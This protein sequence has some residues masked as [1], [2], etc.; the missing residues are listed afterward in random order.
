M[1]LGVL[2]AT[3]DMT[4][5][6]NRQ[7]A[8][9]L[10]RNAAIG[11]DARCR[12]M[13]LDMRKR[14]SNRRAVRRD[15]ALVACNQRHDRHRLRGAQC[16]IPARAMFELTLAHRAKLAAGNLAVEQSAKRVAVNF[17]LQPYFIGGLTFP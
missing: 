13:A 6:G 16:Q 12:H 9:H 5:R 3:G 11:A 8:G 15:Q 10:P 7:F 2:L 1:Q 14:G 17:A 4:E